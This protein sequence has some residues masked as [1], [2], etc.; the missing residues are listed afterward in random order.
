M[1]VDGDTA[2]LDEK[3][4]GA[5]DRLHVARIRLAVL[6]R[7]ELDV[8]ELEPEM[9][10]DRACEIGVRAAAEDHEPLLRSTLDPVTP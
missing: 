3:D 2:R 8:A 1:L 4:V 10:R 9:L 5:A 6:E 7:L